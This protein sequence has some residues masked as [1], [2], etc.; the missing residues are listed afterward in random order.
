MNVPPHSHDGGSG[1]FP[2]GS[3]SPHSHHHSLPQRWQWNGI[4]IMPEPSLTSNLVP[5]SLQITTVAASQLV[6]S[7]LKRYVMTSAR[8]LAPR[9]SWRFVMRWTFAL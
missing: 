4:A 5:H 8:A 2:V 1:S 6:P 3:P 7:Y 9:F